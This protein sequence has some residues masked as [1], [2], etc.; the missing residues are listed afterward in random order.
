MCVCV[1]V[2]V[3]MCVC[4]CVCT[5]AD[6]VFNG[7]HVTERQVDEEK[8]DVVREYAIVAW[9]GGAEVPYPSD[10][11]PIAVRTRRFRR[12]G[13]GGGVCVCLSAC[14]SVCLVC[15]SVCLSVCLCVCPSVCLS[16]CLSVRM[17][18]WAN[19]HAYRW[20]RQRRA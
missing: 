1:C 18:Q 8:Y 16:V 13:G 11:V 14:L 2:C 5:R 20:L 15:V 17:A 7:S 9:P 3:C 12:Y 6:A 4:V 19:E 10:D